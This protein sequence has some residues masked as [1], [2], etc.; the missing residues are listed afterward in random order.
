[1]F[2]WTEWFR[3][4]PGFLESWI[5][6]KILKISEYTNKQYNKIGGRLANIEKLMPAVS[7]ILN[8]IKLSGDTAV[9]KYTYKF[10]GAEIKEMKVSDA[11]FKLA[12]KSVDKESVNALK[13]SIKNIEEFHKK[14][15]PKEELLTS[16]DGS[17]LGR[18]CLPLESVGVYVPGGKASYPS[19][20]LMA[21]IPAKIAGVKRIAVCTPPNKDGNVSSE[22][23]AAAQ[24]LGINEVYKVGGVQAIGAMAYGTKSI[25]RVQKIVGPGN[26]YVTA[27]KRR[28]YGVVDIDFLAG[29]SEVL[30]I[31]D[32][33]AEPGFI[34]SDMLAQIEHDPEAASI[35]V[36]NS[37]DLAKKVKDEIKKQLD[38]LSRKKIAEASLRKNASIIIVESL[39]DAVNFANEYAPE[40]IEIITKNDGEIFRDIKNA[41][42]IFLGRYSAVALGDYCSGTNHILPTGGF[43]RVSSGVSVDT[44]I[45]KPTYQ[46]ISEE[47]LL[48]LS[49]TAMKLAAI[50][51]LDAHAK[52]IEIRVKALEK[53]KSWG[54]RSE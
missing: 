11:E 3:N 21:C 36:T 38:T 17:I 19:T 9:R 23:L 32:N 40:H 4:A 48:R 22:I 41:G 54:V 45:K 52:S 42:S 2:R 16:A 29:P 5:M 13:E 30:I 50:E 7:K 34:A 8:D 26:A 14:Q 27:A 20:L 33:T 47:G 35:L 18:R 31:A 46:K 44:F 10:D 43:A 1:M 53:R 12:V 39:Q 25:P 24:L 51:G 6:L 49:K 37:K 28:V 15:K